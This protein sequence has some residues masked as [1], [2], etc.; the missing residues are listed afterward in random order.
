MSNKLK[1][2][3]TN[4]RALAT[5]GQ[6]YKVWDTEVSG[7]HV[8]VTKAGSKSFAFFYRTHDGR[9]RTTRIGK[10]T[11][12]VIE[13][14]ER[15]RALRVQ[16]DQGEDPSQERKGRLTAPT[17]ADLWD[18]YLEQHAKPNKK[19]RSVA[20][21]ERLWRLHLSPRFAKEK[22][23]NV[24]VA[25]VRT[26]MS[27]MRETPVAAN[28]SLALLSKMFTFAIQNEWRETNPCRAISKFPENQI[29]RY[30]S[31][32]ETER[33][34]AACDADDNPTAARIVEFLV[35][36]GAR[37][38]E[39]FAMEWRHLEGMAS[40][41]PTWV[42][43][44]GQQKGE[45]ATRRVFR[46]Q[47]SSE[48]AD[49]L[50]RWKREC[51]TPSVR[52]VFPSP[53]KPEQPVKCIKTAWE[54]IR[55]RANLTE[56]RIHDLRHSFASFAVNNGASLYAV[57]GALGHKDPKTTKRYAHLADETVRGVASGVGALVGSFRSR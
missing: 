29:E 36:T 10:T 18:A 16:V 21:D 26:M 23:G 22:V 50:R 8:R 14:R 6:D 43:P 53:R 7:L 9:Q 24:S 40:D 27:K 32:A 4:V 20:E 49:I 46:R 52:H 37:K 19:P 44:A 41:S 33:L 35:L 12:T 30:L 11:M 45:R 17:M 34:L 28:R 38:N 56:V 55:Q 2:T 13:A 47:L 31:A 54:R 1:F 48:A 51:P 42:I 25:E 15:A 3:N 57:G 39:V 5:R